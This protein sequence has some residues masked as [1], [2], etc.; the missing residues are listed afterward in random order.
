MFRTVCAA[1]IILALVSC[2]DSNPVESEEPVV[3]SEPIAEEAVVE[4]P[5]PE[6]FG[7]STA[8]RVRVRT[9]PYLDAATRGHL[10]L[11]DPVAIFESTTE[12][13]TINEMSAKW[14][15]V[16]SPAGLTGWAFG[17]FIE[18]R[19]ESAYRET[20]AG[21][22]VAT[23]HIP[24]EPGS[25][26][27]AVLMSGRWSVAGPDAAYAIDF[28]PEGLEMIGGEAFA[29]S[30]GDAAVAPATGV[31]RIRNG[32]L[33]T[34]LVSRGGCSGTEFP[35]GLTIWNRTDAEGAAPAERIEALYRD[36]AAPILVEH[37]DE[38]ESGTSGVSD[39]E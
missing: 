10:Y 18:E 17:A 28:A 26:E 35:I 11:G 16:E 14:H 13:T 29:L 33:V 24:W 22:S 15:R 34:E 30:C 1:T 6:A 27:A 3:R 5:Q 7:V 9:G 39:G 32:Y 25:V 12:E 37:R 21:L 4:P 36:D 38:S 19:T 8:Q 2:G 23:V 20:V 31:W